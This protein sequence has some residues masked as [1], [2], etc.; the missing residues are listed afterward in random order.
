[1]S[2]CSPKTIEEARIKATD[3]RRQAR[4]LLD[5]AEE[6]D[7]ARPRL[8]VD[9]EASTAF[10][11]YS[12]IEPSR[13]SIAAL[14]RQVGVQ[15]LISLHDGTLTVAEVSGDFDGYSLPLSPEEQLESDITVLRTMHASLIDQLRQEA[16]EAGLSPDEVLDQDAYYELQDAALGRHSTQSANSVSDDE[17]EAAI[18]SAEGGFLDQQLSHI[19]LAL[20]SLPLDQALAHLRGI[21]QQANQSRPAGDAP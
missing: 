7:G 12:N 8:L 4:F 17:A 1:M 16:K 19:E 18:G 5:Q 20:L 2:D 11:V 15:E 13:D 6:L 21:F 9:K 3:L 10:L 14:E